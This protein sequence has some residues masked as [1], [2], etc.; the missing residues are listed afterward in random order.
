MDKIDAMR[1]FVQVLDSGGFSPAADALGCHKATISYQVSKLEHRLGARLLTRTTRQMTA[2]AEGQTY[3]QHAV[4]LLA[5]F[6]AA[7]QAIRNAARVPAGT[8]RVN[9]PITLGHIVFIPH[10]HE[11]Q[12]RHPRV[13]LDMTCSDHMA[14]LVSEGVDCAIRCGQ[15]PDS[16]MRCRRIGNVPFVLC[17]S[18]KYLQRSPEPKHPSELKR[19]LLVHYRSSSGKTRSPTVLR[20]G[21][22]EVSV[23]MPTQFMATD[24][25]TVLRAGLAGL[26]IIQVSA[27]VA[28]AYVHTG[29]LRIVLADWRAAELPLYFLSPNGR[30][31]SARVQAFMDWAGELLR[32][33]LTSEAL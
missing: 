10:L 21:S 29:E 33:Q 20:K 16:G 25:A 5:Q 24:S 7:E 9:V 22:E 6:D 19:H 32:R 4:A 23:M 17:A 15:L 30:Y 14:D 8:L 1:A 26:G 11:F 28:Q 13:V 3:Y 27:L 31:R 2:T 12:A 18:P